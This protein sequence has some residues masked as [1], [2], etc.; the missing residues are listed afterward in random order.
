VKNLTIVESITTIDAQVKM[1]ISETLLLKLKERE[2]KNFLLTPGD[3]EGSGKCQ[4]K[5][6]E[7]L[8]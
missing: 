2:S 1:K 3:L 4:G 8:I 5:S 7:V 6:T